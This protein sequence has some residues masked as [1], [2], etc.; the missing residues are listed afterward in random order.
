M[1]RI[2]IIESIYAV[3]A[4]IT[5]VGSVTFELPPSIAGASTVSLAMISSSCII[6]ITWI[7]VAKLKN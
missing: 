1:K 2:D 5:G 3:V 4:I 7:E 6:M